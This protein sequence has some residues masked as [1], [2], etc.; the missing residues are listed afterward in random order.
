M[1]R[2]NG[3]SRH[4][5]WYTDLLQVLRL[6]K[7]KLRRKVVRL[8]VIYVAVG[9]SVACALLPLVWMVKTSFES[10]E[11]IRSAPWLMI[12]PGL[13][14]SL[15]VMGLNFIGDGLRDLLDPRLR[16]TA[17]RIGSSVV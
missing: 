11:F 5:G 4:A 2:L 12:F 7:P 17:R 8:I 9:L 1:T 14:I 16:N 10:R 13:A 15:A 6:A 3:T